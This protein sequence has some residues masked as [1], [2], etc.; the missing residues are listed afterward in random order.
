[1]PRYAHVSQSRVPPRPAEEWDEEVL[2][3]IPVLRR[4]LGDNVESTP[5]VLATFAWYPEL[6]AS[7]LNYNDHL[8]FRSSLPGR[9][10]E[11]V[12]L[13][14][15]WLRASDYEWAQHTR[16]ARGLGVSEEEI[17]AVCVGSQAGTWESGEAAM[18]QAVEEIAADRS[19]SESTWKKLACELSRQQL[20]DLLFTIGTYDML[21]MV[22]GTFGLQLD[23]GLAGLDQLPPSLRPI[24]RTAQ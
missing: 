1:M 3:A 5:N 8:L 18:L 10:R 17:Q 11:L 23:P 4:F 6:A 2:N 12:I 14:I 7:W 21:S 13:R 20:M 15:S 19:L 22:F 24:E 9:A 16:L